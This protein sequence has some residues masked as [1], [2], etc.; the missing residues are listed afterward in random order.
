MEYFAVYVGTEGIPS[1]KVE[2]YLRRAKADFTKDKRPDDG[3]F[4]LS[5]PERRGARIEWL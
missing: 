5:D 1:D 2:E 4:F 3:F